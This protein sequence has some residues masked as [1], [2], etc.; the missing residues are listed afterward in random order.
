M[1]EVATHG[2]FPVPVYFSELERDFTKKELKFFDKNKLTTYPNSGNIT[3]EDAYILDNSEL[4]DLKSEC[5]VAVQRYV[6]NIMSFKSTVQPYITQSWLN[7]TETGQYHHKHAHSNSIISGVIY[8]NADEENDKIYFYNEGYKQIKPQ[9]NEWNLYNSESWYFTVK[10]GQVVLFPSNLTH[11]VQTKAGDNTR[12]SLA[13]NVF[14]KGTIG[15]DRE[16]TELK[17]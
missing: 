1:K 9:I 8:V 11:M 17:L 7:F 10:T 5:M 2:I 15:V 12:I 14:L 3:S 13:F 4:A 16:L 6:D